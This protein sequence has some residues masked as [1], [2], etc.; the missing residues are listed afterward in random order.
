LSDWLTHLAKDPVMAE[1]IAKHGELELTQRDDYFKSLTRAIVGQQLSVKAASTIYGRFEDKLKIVNSENVAR[2][3]VEEAR[4]LGL[5]RQ[6]Y[7]YLQDLAINVAFKDLLIDIEHADDEAV[8]TILTRVKGIG[9]W[10][11]EMFLMFTLGREDVFAVDD[12][13]LRRAIEKHYGVKKDSKLPK[14]E[15]IAKQW[16]PWRSHASMYLWKSLD[17]EPK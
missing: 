11:A 4:A 3:K 15:A 12:L 5:S 7:S 14:Y 2:L 17:N 6:K 9:R 1:L 8:I 13:G 16:V 10:T